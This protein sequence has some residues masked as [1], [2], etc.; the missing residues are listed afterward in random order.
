MFSIDGMMQV[1]AAKCA[2]TIVCLGMFA[3]AGCTQSTLRFSPDFGAAVRQDEAAQIADPDARYLGTPAPGSGGQ[4]VGLAQKRYDT[5]QVIPPLDIG[6]S[7]TAAVNTNTNGSNAGGNGSGG[8]GG[9][10]GTGG[11]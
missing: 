3:L 6:A 7:N 8:S 1:S 2:R 10:M 11:P 5:N 9:S 4:R